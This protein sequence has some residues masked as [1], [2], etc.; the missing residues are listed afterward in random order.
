MAEMKLIGAV[1]IKVRP[2]ARDFKRELNSQINDLPEKTVNV[3]VDA[4]TRDAERKIKKA[5]D[6]AEREHIT[7]H[8]GVDYDGLRNA[9]QQLR[10]ALK[11]AGERETIKV[12]LDADNLNKA[13]ADIK[14][15]VAKAEIQM[16]VANDEAGFRAVLAKIEQIKR[17]KTE[18]EVKFRADDKDLK[19]Q[20]RETRRQLEQ[21]IINK[22]VKIQYVEDRDGLARAIATI[23]D[24]LRNLKKVEINPKLNKEELMRER[25]RLQAELDAKP[26]YLKINKDVEGYDAALKKIRDLQREA[27]QVKF[28]YETDEAGLKDAAEKLEKWKQQAIEKAGVLVHYKSDKAGLEAAIAELDKHLDKFKQ[29]TI[30][31]KLNEDSLRKAREKLVKQLANVNVDISYNDDREGLKKAVAEL[32]TLKRKAAE[33]KLEYKNDEAGLD[34]ALDFMRQKLD[35]EPVSTKLVPDKKGY[36]AVLGQIEELQRQAKAIDFEYHTDDQSLADAADKMRRNIAELPVP[37][38]F[39]YDDNST[40]IKGALAEVEKKLK[41]VGQIELTAEMNEASLLAAKE[42][43]EGKLKESSFEIK[44]NTKDLASLRKE[45]ERLAELYREQTGEVVSLE[46][47]MDKASIEHAARQIDDLINEAEAKP[48]KLD[49]EPVGLAL[50][51]S[52]IGWASRSRVVPFF[53]R[54]DNKSRAIAEGVIK[55]LSGY[56]TLSSL[57]RTV[58]RLMTNF[59]TAIVKGGAITTVL[60]NIINSLGFAATNLLSIG[61]GMAQVVGLAAAAPAALSAAAAIVIVNIAAFRDFKNAMDGV[62]GAMAKLPPNAQAAAKALKGTWEAIQ[63]PIQNAYWETMGTSLQDMVTVLLPKVKDGLAVAGGFIGQFA[64]NTADTLS[65]LGTG[66]MFDKMFANLG[67]FFEQAAGIAEPLTLALNTL[68]LRGSEYLPEFGKWLTDITTQFN[69][70]IQKA[71]EAGDINKWIENGVQSLQDM[72]TAG[73]GV[74]DVIRGITGAAMA[75]G[76]QTL[77]GF[78]DEMQR[79]GEIANGEPFQSRLTTIFMGAR[80]GASNLNAGFMD[81]SRSI[82]EAAE[83]TALMLN[84]LGQL[85]GVTL[86]NIATMFRNDTFKGGLY[87]AVRGLSDMMRDLRPAFSDVATLIGTLG[88]TAAATFRGLAPLIN[89]AAGALKDVAEILG[90]ELPGVATALTRAMTNTFATIGAVL[91]TVAYAI[92]PILKLFNAMPDSI[93]AIVLAAAGFMV[94]RGQLSKLF[95]TLSEKPAF[96]RFESNWR[97][98]RDTAGNSANRMQVAGTMI[99]QSISRMAT[100]TGGAFASMRTSWTNYTTAVANSTG[101]LSRTWTAI[102]MPAVKATS[103]IKTALSGVVGFLGGPWG[104][105]IAAAG[106]GISLFAQQQAK[107]K[108]QIDA[109]AASLDAQTGAIT[110]G[111]KKLVA[112]KWMQN[113]TTAWDNFWRGAVKNSK[114][115]HE[116]VTALGDSTFEV[117]ELILEGGEAYDDYIDK[118]KLIEKYIGGAKL[119]YSDGSAPYKSMEELS[120]ITGYTEEQLRSINQADMS[121]LIGET[122]GARD[123]LAE[124]ERKTAAFGTALGVSDGQAG[125]MQAALEGLNSET[126]TASERVDDFKL[127]LD[128][129]NNGSLSVDEA[130]R[131]WAKTFESGLEQI[132]TA[133]GTT[134]EGVQ[135]HL[136]HLVDATTGAITDMRGKGGELYDAT[137]SI[138]DGLIQKAMAA[139]QHVLDMDGSVADAQAAALAAMQM[140]DGELEEFAKSVGVSTETAR[141]MLQRMTGEDWELKAI[142]SADSELFFEKKAEAEREG[143]VFGQNEWTA[144]LRARNLANI[145]IDEAKA[146]GKDWTETE[147]NAVLRATPESAMQTLAQTLGVMDEG[148]RRGDFSAIMTALDGTSDGVRAALLSLATVTDGNYEA[149]VQALL[150]AISAEKT[151]QGLDEVANPNNADRSANITA[152]PNT[153]NA[154]L[155]LNVTADPRTSDITG[156][157]HTETAKTELDT[158]AGQRQAWFIGMPNVVS[159]AIALANTASPRDAWFNGQTNANGANNELNRIADDRKPRFVPFVDEIAKNG[160]LTTLGGLAADVGVRIKEA[161]GLA[162]GGILNGSGVQ[163]FANGGLF[164]HQV[165]AYAGGGFENHTAQ[166]SRGQTPYRIWSEPETGGEA[167]I[168]MGVHKRG[169]STQILEQVAHQFG[170][171]LTRENTTQFANGGVVNGG[172]TGAGVAVNIGSY[173]TQQ[174]DTPD[175]V[176]RALMRRIKARGAYSP[177]EAF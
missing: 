27:A 163:L 61:D 82:G 118:L 127:A 81:L 46:V 136:D 120:R 58:E 57:G 44:V 161:L 106:I 144:A 111:T 119:G 40:G 89:V 164:S 148:W 90:D 115:A 50:A 67:G 62:K 48:I 100:S 25:Q 121:N 9:Q 132:T 33:V 124:A 31:P 122:E 41:E 162:N 128:R 150:D 77:S 38:K 73:D 65:M 125:K 21:A 158:T 129:L 86:T 3:K 76:G 143:K 173:V 29:L 91:K 99:N 18:I 28:R 14:D 168:P 26:A 4:D 75:A 97:S 134:E 140:T 20:E 54:I 154:T 42:E 1:G 166:I 146:D 107:A 56:N 5:K 176:A 170:Y 47:E 30:N 93:Q 169:R 7:L 15:R 109:T 155:A 17:A 137:K 116:A 74:I 96:Q 112:E 68:G 16:H 157:P 34:A 63:Q 135:L 37:V 110:E 113:G 64:K 95:T 102:S 151:K 2:V 174:S 123:M 10:Q 53:I 85:G 79:W 98:A 104:A 126:S 13:L 153:N 141:L 78:A 24:A 11:Q 6:D 175:D 133:A 84:S 49:V 60:G 165:N 152:V 101:P 114:A 88:T 32:E 35:A 160:V 103:G 147:L 39:K 51:A 23:D 71:D 83:W 172:S 22:G 177:M 8:V 52:Q 70:W 117:N 108:G 149:P 138:S 12:K 59:D 87:E 171:A 92:E 145:G 159:A 66:E 69:N 45:R 80:A 139:S 19:R 130:A 142:L 94:M 72:W 156:V 43:L 36:E 55:S 131:N 105:A 167:Y